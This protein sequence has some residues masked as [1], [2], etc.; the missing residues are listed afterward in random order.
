MTLIEVLVASLLVSLIAV[1]TFAGFDSATRVSA[2]E[3]AHT[4]ATKLTEQDEE[5]LRGLTATQLASLGSS[6]RTVTENGTAFTITSSARFVSASKNTLTC[7]SKA[8][9]ADYIQT[10]SSATWPALGSRPPVSQA[11]TF[12]TGLLVTVNNRGEEPVAGATVKISGTSNSGTQITPAAGCV[13][14]V[15]L[16]PEP[17]LTVE[18]SKSPWVDKNGKSPPPTKTVAILTEHLATTEFTIAPPGSIEAEFESNKLAA[19]GDTFVAFQSGI[20]P[21]EDFVGTAGSYLPTVTLGGLFPFAKAGTPPTPEAYFVYAGECS[22]N[23]PETVTKEGEKRKPREALVE[24]N[25]VAT[26]KIEAPTV[27]VKV[28][29]GESESVKGS[30][31]A[32]S[33]NATIFNKACSGASAQNAATLTGKHSVIIKAGALVQKYQPYATELVLCVVWKEGEHAYYKKTFPSFANALQAGTS[34][35]NFFLKSAPVEK[36]TTE[37]KC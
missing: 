13:I 23:N 4:E 14:F 27:N 10:T 7:E 37:A 36:T 6:Q 18:V 2:D 25:L 22:A 33:A 20:S 21:P 28:Y 26:V 12:V 8:G 19:T 3:R 29:S 30:L 17:S 15:G 32:E 9:T 35:P 1:G 16:T 34:P 31:I 5:R 11:S 24:P